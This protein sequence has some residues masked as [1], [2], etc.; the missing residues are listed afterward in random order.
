MK[1]NAY[2]VASVIGLALAMIVSVLTSNALASGGGDEPR[3]VHVSGTQT[4]TDDPM[5]YDTQGDLVGTWTV[6]TAVDSTNTPTLLIQTGKEKFEGCIDRRGDG[7][8]GRRD[9]SGTMYFDYIYW[10]SFDADKNLTKGQCVHPATGGTEDFA[11]VRGVINM[12][13]TPVGEVI[14]TTYEGDIELNAVD[15]G[16]A[17]PPV[18]DGV[19]VMAGSSQ[20][21]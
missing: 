10:A 5:V 13:D 20:V 17:A 9:L 21:C 3:T 19:A 15:E 8:C 18:A 1:T 2:R 12:Y 11:G 16:D 6:L 4:V 14:E 7:H